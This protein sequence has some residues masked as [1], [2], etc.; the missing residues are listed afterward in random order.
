MEN[1]RYRL[2]LILTIVLPAC[3]VS[4]VGCESGVSDK[5]IVV[6]SLPDIIDMVEKQNAGEARYAVFIDP[7]APKYYQQGHLPGAINYRLPDAREKDPPDRAIQAHKHIVIYGQ[8]PGSAVARAMF[9]RMYAIGYKRLQFYPGGIDEW[10]KA[11]YQLEGQSQPTAPESQTTQ[12][13][14]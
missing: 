7:R 6:V 13:A 11:G 14:Q 9:K 4:L 10:T 8:N 12:P 5:D 3:L 2:C 1:T